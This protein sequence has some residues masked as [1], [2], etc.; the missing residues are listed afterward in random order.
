MHIPLESILTPSLTQ[1]TPV[2][3]GDQSPCLVTSHMDEHRFPIHI[4]THTPHAIFKYIQNIKS[5]I[6]LP[7]SQAT[8]TT[9]PPKHD[10]HKFQDKTQTQMRQLDIL[11]KRVTSHCQRQGTIRY[12][13][14]YRSNPQRD[15]PIRHHHGRCDIHQNN[16]TH[17]VN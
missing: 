2:G 14:R 10:I 16:T 17:T 8:N 7:M 15:K 9:S 11:E 13:N 6:K 4:H 12:H 1:L 3:D 5:L